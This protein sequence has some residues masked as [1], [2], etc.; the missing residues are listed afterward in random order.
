MSDFVNHVDI[1]LIIHRDSEDIKIGFPFDPNQDSID[2][3]CAE[4]VDALGLNHEEELSVRESIKS[5][6]EQVL[7]ESY[8]DLNTSSG[9]AST[10]LSDSFDEEVFSDPEYQALLQHQRAEITAL[11]ELHFKQQRDLMNGNLSPSSSHKAVDD[12]I[13]FS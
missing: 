5:Q 6:L 3:I 13:V 7:G 9:H 4:L 10:D 11:E 2:S 1:N 12:L 8:G